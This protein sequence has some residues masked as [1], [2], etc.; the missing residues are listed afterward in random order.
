MTVKLTQTGIV[1]AQAL[2]YVLVVGASLFT[3][4]TQVQIRSQAR[5]L[6]QEKRIHW[7]ALEGVDGNDLQRTEVPTG[8]IVESEDGQL[9]VVNDPDKHWL[10]EIE[11][12]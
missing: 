3:I 11:G 5:Q 12:N 1:C 2:V 4:L 8:W 10:E 6:Q 7:D 9:V